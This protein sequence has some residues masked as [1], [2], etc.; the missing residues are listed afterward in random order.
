MLYVFLDLTRDWLSARGC[1]WAF[2][3]FDRLTFRALAAAIL[4]FFAVL[5]F[6]RPVIAW[7]ARKKIGDSGLTDAEAL[8]VRMASRANVPT[9]GGLLIAAAILAASILLADVR[10]FYVILAL[11][12]LVWLAAVGFADDWLKLNA[13]SRPGASRQG[14]FAWE[15][16]V[17]QLGLG[18]LIGYFTYSHG[19]TE[20]PHDLAHVLNLP[21]QKTY[22]PGS[23]GAVLSDGLVY[24]DRWTFVLLS[25][26]MITGMS[27]AVNIT[28]GMDGLATGI[29]GAVALGLLVLAV[30]AGWPLA[31]QYLLVPHVPQSDELAVVAGAMGGACLGFLWWNCAPAHVFMGD[32][33]ALALGGLLGYI[34]VV[35][36]QEILVLFMSTVF[37]LEI[38]SVVLQVGYF[39]ATGG[40]RIFRVAPYHHHL[41]LS[42]WTEQQVVVRFW[43]ISVLL[44]VTALASIK[45]R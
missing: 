3:V 36:R 11:I 14:L 45:I 8:R 7:L 19:L 4:A 35:I 27:N 40:K 42:G 26:L 22:V 21:F 15:K 13:A 29:S 44:V 24:L 38:G 6:G 33:G 39:K 41:H 34:A 18:L 10:N 17:F 12:V 1:Y 30:I 43:I 23:G 20:A 16:L 9:M 32:T 31:A 25:T 37:I 28:D 5:R 2:M